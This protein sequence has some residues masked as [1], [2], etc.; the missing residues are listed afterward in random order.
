MRGCHR[1]GYQE[2]TSQAGADESPA[3]ED[4]SYRR[5]KLAPGVGL[6]YKATSARLESCLHDIDRAILAYK[7]NS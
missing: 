2:V 3:F 6:D 1:R 7:Q 5:Q 4:G